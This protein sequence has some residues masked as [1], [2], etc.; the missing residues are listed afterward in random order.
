MPGSGF[1]EKRSRTGLHILQPITRTP[2]QS[3]MFQ[4]L[5]ECLST[6][7]QCQGFSLSPTCEPGW[8]TLGLFND[9]S[10]SSDPH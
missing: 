9:D 4:T 1:T 10:V 7:A 6:R 2:A 3:G 5:T 8:R